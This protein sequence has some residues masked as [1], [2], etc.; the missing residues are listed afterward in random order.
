MA[1][2]E[3][4]DFTF[5]LLV[6]VYYPIVE[7]GAYG[8]V[9]KTWVLDKSICCNFNATGNAGN[10]EIKPNVNI[11]REAILIG[12]VK[13]D[14]RISSLEDRNAVTNVI[15]TN[16]RTST[17]TSIYNETAG[18]R[19][20]KPTIFEIASNEPYLGP[21]GSVEYYSLVIRRSENQGV[22]V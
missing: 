21:F 2:C 13:T 8:N 1:T 19:S 4:T 10:E 17:G 11:T 18:P 3:T 9:K 14:I 22:D 15:L 7:Q 20:G 16:I 6:D 12:R 5:P